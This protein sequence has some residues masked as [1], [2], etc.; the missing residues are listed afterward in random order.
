MSNKCNY[1]YSGIINYYREIKNY[2]VEFNFVLFR[3]Q[4]GAYL[5]IT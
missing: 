1:V 4:L 5:L 2:F 3:V